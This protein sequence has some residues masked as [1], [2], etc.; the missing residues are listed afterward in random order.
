MK[1][2]QLVASTSA[3]TQIVLAC[4]PTTMSDLL[5]NLKDSMEKKPE[6][7]QLKIISSDCKS[8]EIKYVPKAAPKLDHDRVINLNKYYASIKERIQKRCSIK[9]VKKTVEGTS[10]ETMAVATALGKSSEEGWN[11]VRD[12]LVKLTA[13][14]LP[15]IHHNCH[16]NTNA[17]RQK[18]L[19]SV[20]I[21][22]LG[23][24]GRQIL[25]NGFPFETKAMYMKNL[26]VYYSTQ[27]YLDITAILAV[28]LFLLAA[29]PESATLAINNLKIC[30]PCRAWTKSVQSYKILL[31][32]IAGKT[33]IYT[34]A[35]GPK[36]IDNLLGGWKSKNG[37]VL[38]G[39]EE[40]ELAEQRIRASCPY[41]IEIFYPANEPP[42]HE[43][44][45]VETERHQ[46]LTGPEIQ[47]IRGKRAN[48][49][50]NSAQKRELG[51][52]DEN[53]VIKYETPEVDSGKTCGQW[54]AVRCTIGS[55]VAFTA[56]ILVISILMMAKIYPQELYQAIRRLLHLEI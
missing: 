53:G 18:L 35:T 42:L 6:I 24:E 3:A 12:H 28:I 4:S 11:E 47:A 34:L 54:R 49:K 52:T 15:T 20:L 21:E 38:Q 16:G 23:E 51:F 22:L 5:E 8:V 50:L 19:K 13:I 1:L 31:T 41:D 27:I 17:I 43:D 26:A 44:D 40:M 56:Y 46:R 2:I 10:R 9:Q 30:I 55:I 37:K 45:Q 25:R 39:Y 33:G 29:V 7:N 32:A 48:L 14:A 36:A